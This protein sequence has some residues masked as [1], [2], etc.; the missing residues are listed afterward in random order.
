MRTHTLVHQLA[1]HQLA[2]TTAAT[3][4]G[5]MKR[6]LQP[7]DENPDKS[8]QKN[9]AHVNVRS[10]NKEEITED[11]RRSQSQQVEH[12][13]RGRKLAEKVVEHDIESTKG[14]LKGESVGL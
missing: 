2:A 9:I 8:R 5:R 12:R 7:S 4:A 6:M 14:T 10:Q 1:A 13:C 3:V 11:T